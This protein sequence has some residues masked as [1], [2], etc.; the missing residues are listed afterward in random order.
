[1]IQQDLPH[2]GAGLLRLR[3]TARSQA[4]DRKL[5]APLQ[6]PPTTQI[7]GPHPAGRVS[8]ETIPPA[9]T[10]DWIRNSRGLHL[11]N[12]REAMS[13]N[14]ANTGETGKKPPTDKVWVFGKWW[15][16]GTP[17]QTTIESTES[18]RCGLLRTSANRSEKPAGTPVGSGRSSRFF[19]LIGSRNTAST[20]SAFRGQFNSR[21]G[22]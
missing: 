8:C 21:N 17:H 11:K 4:D 10:S 7:P 2:R 16:G 5:A 22:N 19:G 6:L 15:W 12:A 18:K 20:S 14:H 13:R 3:F 1:M 9:S